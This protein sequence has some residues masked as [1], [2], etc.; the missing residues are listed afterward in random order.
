[1]IK[2]L[3]LLVVGLIGITAG[4]DPRRTDLDEIDQKVLVVIKP[5]ETKEVLLC[6]YDVPGGRAPDMALSEK[7]ELNREERQRLGTVEKYESHGVTATLDWKKGN[8]IG[9]QLIEHD[10]KFWLVA[11]VKVVAGPQA[12]PG[13]FF[14]Y[15]HY[16]A[17]T[18]RFVY[19]RG[20]ISVLVSKD[21]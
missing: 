14:L 3:S 17:G 16:A 13:P 15:V 6:W 2:R 12:T 5:G 21:K 4:D 10:R 9:T 19:R 20:A 18:G 11:A 8:E 1:V 7:P